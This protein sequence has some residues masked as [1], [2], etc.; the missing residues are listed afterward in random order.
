LEEC[1]C[2][3][4]TALIAQ[5]PGKAHGGAQFPGQG[6]LLASPVKRLPEVPLGCPRSSAGALQQ[7]KL[8]VDARQLG[9]QPV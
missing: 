3:R 9:N 5:Q 1:D 4:R 7:K 8:A 2:I 6:A